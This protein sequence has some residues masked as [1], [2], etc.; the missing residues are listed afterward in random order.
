LITNDDGYDTLYIQT[1]FEYIRDETCHTPTMV[2]PKVG[3]SGAGATLDVFTPFV[4]GVD[5]GNPEE[6]IHF[7]DSTPATSTIYGLDVIFKD[8]KG[9]LPDLVVSGP[10]EGQ[11]IGYLISTSGTVGAAVAALARGIPAIAVSADGTTGGQDDPE[12]A[13][14]VAGLT[15][16]LIDTVLIDSDTES[17]ILGESEG[18][19]VNIPP[20][21]GGVDDYEFELTKVGRAY[22]SFGGLYFFSDFADDPLDLT[23]GFLD[24]FPGMGL[25]A[26]EDAGYPADEDPK[27]EGNV[28]GFSTMGPI[29]GSGTPDPVFV[30]TASPITFSYGTSPPNKVRKAFEKK[31][32]KS[33][34]SKSKSSKRSKSSK[35]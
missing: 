3:Q 23:G 34:S 18:L 9:F 30:V 17:L 28:H 1:L 27:S 10:N 4:P 12:K 11:N 20:I 21:N 22:P 24:G 32:K 35:S 33:K 5:I 16:K 26:M 25:Q 15:A 7:L 31:E 19:N 13:K 8:E 14:V 6:G 2:A 29:M